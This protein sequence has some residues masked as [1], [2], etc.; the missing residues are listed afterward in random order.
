VNSSTTYRAEAQLA[1]Q[2]V[3]FPAHQEVKLP[4]R[5]TSRDHE[6]KIVAATEGEAQDMQETTAAQD[7]LSVAQR[8]KPLNFKRTRD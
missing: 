3:V 1:V 8:C 5:Q 4:R 7:R 2:S 6:P